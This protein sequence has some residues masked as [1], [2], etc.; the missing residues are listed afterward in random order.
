MTVEQSFLGATVPP[1]RLTQFTSELGTYA[2]LG[3]VMGA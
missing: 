3:F 2:V 1:A